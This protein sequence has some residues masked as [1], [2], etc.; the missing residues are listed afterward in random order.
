MNPLT[1][2]RKAI[3]LTASLGAGQIVGSIVANTTPQT[4]MYQKV[5]VRTGA[6]VMGYMAGEAIDK[7]LER[8]QIELE[9]WWHENITT[10]AD[11][12]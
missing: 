5:T 3:S 11:S 8:K 2:A 10:K 7:Y 4:T 9:T 12:K 1:L 6:L